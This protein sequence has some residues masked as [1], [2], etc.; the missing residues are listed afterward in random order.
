M[1]VGQRSRRADKQ[2]NRKRKD[3]KQDG[4]VPWRGGGG[5]WRDGQTGSETGAVCYIK[6]CGI[7]WKRVQT[8]L[9][10]A[11]RENEEGETSMKTSSQD[12]NNRVLTIVFTSFF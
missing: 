12:I 8:R 7:S 2:I 11:D 3:G 1:T 5:A 10:G 9:A 6:L 4:R